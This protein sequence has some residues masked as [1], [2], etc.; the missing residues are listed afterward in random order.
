MRIKKKKMD[1]AIELS[2]KLLILY[3]IFCGLVGAIFNE[4]LRELEYWYYAYKEKEQ[5][6]K[7]R[8]SQYL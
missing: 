8:D 4:V 2:L 7:K 3:G 1:N 5:K 6:S